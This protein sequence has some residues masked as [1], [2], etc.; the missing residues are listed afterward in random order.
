MSMCSLDSLNASPC[1]PARVE[2]MQWVLI[3]CTDHCL[4]NA[5]TNLSC[6]PQVQQ[7]CI[8]KE[9][10]N[11]NPCACKHQALQ[12]T[13]QR[14]LFKTMAYKFC[15]LHVA[16]LEHIGELCMQDTVQQVQV[17]KACFARMFWSS[18]VRSS[19]V[20]QVTRDHIMHKSW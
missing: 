17:L 13:T 6:P 15:V 1:M 7:Y 14:P 2:C 20:Q 19:G 12:T 10:N 18:T 9:N 4:L 5:S 16:H 11:N 3:T 8:A